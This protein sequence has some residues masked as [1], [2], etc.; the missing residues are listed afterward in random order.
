MNKLL[1]IAF[2]GFLLF[3]CTT[4]PSQVSQP[5]EQGL[6]GSGPEAD[7]SASQGAA[8][9][10]MYSA[11][12]GEAIPPG[13]EDAFANC[14]SGTTLTSALSPELVYKYLIVGPFQGRCSVQSQFLANPSPAFVG[15]TM[16]CKY[17]N[18]LD[19][20]TAVQQAPEEPGTCVGELYNLL[21]EGALGQ[22][23]E[24]SGSGVSS[25][26][27]TRSIYDSTDE[28]QF[29]SDCPD[30][31]LCLAHS[32]FAS[33]EEFYSEYV[34]CCGERTR[35]GGVPECDLIRPL[36]NNL[37]DC[38]E[39]TCENCVEGVQRCNGA[40]NGDLTYNYCADCLFDSK[41]EDGYTCKSGRCV[42]G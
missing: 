39:I 21:F 35:I 34:G 6:P 22:E 13:F 5:A 25:Q 41:C 2:F 27:S 10:A 15:P 11:D 4:S 17:D 9:A 37:Q 8:P 19:F 26:S 16:E 20:E 1:L 14:A 7:A 31:M 32:C 38:S 28:C 23:T 30:G 18:S 24:P 42:S 12:G 33:T 3:G 40:Q 29:N 36:T